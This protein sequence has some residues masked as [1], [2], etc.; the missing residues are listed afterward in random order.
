MERKRI[1]IAG[2]GRKVARNKLGEIL[3]PQPLAPLRVQREEPPTETAK[4]AK[5]KRSGHLTDAILRYDKKGADGQLDLFDLLTLTRE[6]K[7]KITSTG[8]ELEMISRR[9]TGITLSK[10]EH[11]VIDCLTE[12]LHE[13]SQT[14]EPKNKDYYVGNKDT[15][16]VE[17]GGKG[18]RAVAPKIAVTLYELTK[19][20][21][22]GEAISGK[23]VENV[24]K[25]L[26]GL[27]DDPDKKVLIRYTRELKTATGNRVKEEV[28]DYQNLIKVLN[29]RR[30]EFNDKD[31][32]TSQ[33]EEIVIVL[34]PIFRDQ[35]ESK[36]IL[37]PKDIVKR[38]IDATGTHNIPEITYRLRDWLARAHSAKNYTP[39]IGLDKLYLTVAG[40]YMKESRKKL[41]KQYTDKAIEAVIKLG[42]LVSYEIKTGQGGELKIVFT[43][44]KDW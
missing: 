3:F 12:L 27:G 35:I 17:Y 21:K 16:V 32:T 37:F 5:F 26:V 24:R 25:L 7:E 41:A 9:G 23:D 13:T 39:E 8:A 33:R 44:N 2:G 36:F 14:A 29:L 15:Q 38:M 4:R 30:T 10:G 18:Q 1:H 6:T 42:L 40:E 43:L 28:E 11:K 34:N 19:K 22:G 20:Y 31:V